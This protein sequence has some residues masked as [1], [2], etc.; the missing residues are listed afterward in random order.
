MP[1]VR[2]ALLEYGVAE[3]LIPDIQRSSEPPGRSRIPAVV[4]RGYSGLGELAGWLRIVAVRAGELAGASAANVNFRSIW[5]PI[6]SC[7]SRRNPESAL[8]AETLKRSFMLP[9]E[10]QSQR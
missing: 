6:R 9:S 5:I 1:G 8:L 3:S 7:D 2:R 10:M 4:R